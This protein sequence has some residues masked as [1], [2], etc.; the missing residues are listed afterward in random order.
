M[1]ARFGVA[2]L[3][4]GTLKLKGKGCEHDARPIHGGAPLHGPP[5]PPPPSLLNQQ[6]ASRSQ[7][8]KDNRGESSGKMSPKKKQ[9]IEAA[10]TA[11][12]GAARSEAGVGAG[13]EAEGAET[14]SNGNGIKGNHQ[15]KGTDENQ[16]ETDSAEAAAATAT[17]WSAHVKGEAPPP[18]RCQ[19]CEGYSRASLCALFK[20]RK[21]Q[22]CFQ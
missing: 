9:R 6:P 8:K 4:S 11:A 5:L 22:W 10:Q 15:S 13:N 12:A 19:A 1:Q 14:V 18:C 17:Y 16:K 20:V 2:L 21:Y 3:D 7:A